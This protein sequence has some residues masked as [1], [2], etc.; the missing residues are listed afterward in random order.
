MIVERAQLLEQLK[1]QNAEL[2][3]SNQLKH[4]FIQVA[5]HEL[6]TPLTILVG[7]TRLAAKAGNI[8][9][10]LKGWMG[11]IESAGKRLQ[12]LVD[13]I[14]SMLVANQ[15]ERE[16]SKEETN[17]AE[18]LNTAADDVR[19]FVELRGQ[20]LDVSLAPDLGRLKL[21]APR[22]RDAMN[23]L[24]LNAIK[25]TPDGGTISLSGS[26]VPADGVVIKVSDNG[27][28]MDAAAREQLFAPFFTGFDVSHHSSGHY[29]HG[30]KG[31]GL[32]LPLVKSFVEMHGGKIEVESE[33]GKGTTFTVTLP[34][35]A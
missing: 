33:A 6:R 16:V 5:S 2:M 31:L 24:L 21:E 4:A 28:G 15:F 17:V 7:L 30:R 14:I 34:G 12:T 13:Q 25:F 35:N 10:P 32:G 8:A 9:E 20:N 22:I 3:K 11:R 26:R 29:E 27:E 19:P 1:A 18:L 23:H